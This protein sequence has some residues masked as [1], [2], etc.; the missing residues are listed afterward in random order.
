MVERSA[1]FEEEGIAV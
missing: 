1:R